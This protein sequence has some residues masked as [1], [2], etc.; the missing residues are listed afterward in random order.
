MS[1]ELNKYE[2]KYLEYKKNI[3]A[4]ISDSVIGGGPDTKL[5]LM[6]IRDLLHYLVSKKI[7]I[8]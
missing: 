2:D 5:T 6:Y 1:K 7:E 4:L 3:K 8:S